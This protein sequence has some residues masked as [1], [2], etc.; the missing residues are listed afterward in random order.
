M[1]HAEVTKSLA[2][3]DQF[4]LQALFSPQKS[5]DGTESSIPPITVSIP[6]SN[7]PQPLGGKSHLII[8]TKDTFISL[9]TT[10]KILRL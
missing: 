3:G 9:T 7:Q 8:I 10:S 4:N 1:T 6:P 5:S 2:T